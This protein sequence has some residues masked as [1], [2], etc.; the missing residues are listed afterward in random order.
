MLKRLLP[1]AFLATPVLAQA[2]AVP[3]LDIRMYDLTDINFNGSRGTGPS[4]E[5]GFSIG[6]S[7]CNTGTVNLPWQSQSGGVMVDQYPRITFLLARENG[8][9]FVQVCGRSYCKHSPTAFNFSSGPC[10]PC[11]ASGGA[12]F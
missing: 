2:N 5:A 10:A 12:F 4:S 11:T 6:H 8:G 3:G 9:R 1:L 7:W